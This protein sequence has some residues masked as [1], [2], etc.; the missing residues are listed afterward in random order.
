MD[1]RKEKILFTIIKEHI[2][3]GTPVGSTA[4]VEKYKLDVS[5]AT[6]RNDMADLEQMGYIVQPH[7]SA[8]RIPTEIA[9]D[10]Y[11]KDIEEKSINEKDL[12]TIK[13]NL[14]KRDEQSFKQA[15]KA[16]AS[17]SDNAVFWAFHRHNLYYTGLSNLLHQPE[18]NHSN[19]IFD[20][21]TVIDRMDEIINDIYDDFD[22]EPQILIGSKNPFGNFCGTVITKYNLGEHD[23]L[24]GILGPMRMN[25]EKNLGIIKFLHNELK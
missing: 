2:K 3:T 9:Y 10:L 23:G 5:P 15:A 11:V 17:I 20:F 21:S 22:D 19:L 6:V 25:Y 16:I 1:K 13:E 4:L 8:G 14:N 7:T 24:V 18:F 12:K